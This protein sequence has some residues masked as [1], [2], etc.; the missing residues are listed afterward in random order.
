M[1]ELVNYQINSHSEHVRTQIFSEQKYNKEWK[2]TKQQ[3]LLLL[4]SK[5]IL[6]SWSSEVLSM[7]GNSLNRERNRTFGKQPSIEPA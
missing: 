4:L 5:I 6:L 7:E 1:V 3:I 2:K